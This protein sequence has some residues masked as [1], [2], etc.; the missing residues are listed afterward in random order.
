MGV[1]SAFFGKGAIAGCANR[2]FS[3]C[4]VTDVAVYIG[5][6]DVLPR[7]VET[8]QCR[9]EF[10]PVAR[11]VDVVK[12]I[13]NSIIESPSQRQFASLSRREIANNRP[14]PR[15]LDINVYVWLSFNPDHFTAS[16]GFFPAIG[17]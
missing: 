17:S 10:L 6:D 9:A 5:V 12:G 16:F 3:R 14:V 4:L 8:R 15:K 2:N 1:L 13:A 7:C 11:E